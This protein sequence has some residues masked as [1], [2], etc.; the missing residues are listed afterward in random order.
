MTPQLAATEV[1]PQSHRRAGLQWRRIAEAQ[2]DRC[3]ECGSRFTALDPHFYTDGNGNVG[4][5]CL[6]VRPRTSG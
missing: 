1:L 4:C 5:R 3:P 6:G 2:P